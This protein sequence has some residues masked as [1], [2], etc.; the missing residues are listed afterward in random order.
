MFKIFVKES[1]NKK[2]IGV[3][4][5]VLYLVIY[6][7][8]ISKIWLE[9]NQWIINLLSLIFVVLS[10]YYCFTNQ[11]FKNSSKKEKKKW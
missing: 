10:G 7:L 2:R 1:G 6:G 5:F 9:I 3:F 8:Y 4:L 11:E